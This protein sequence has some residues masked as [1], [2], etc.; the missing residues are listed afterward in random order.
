MQSNMTGAIDLKFKNERNGEEKRA[1]LTNVILVPKIGFNLLTVP[2]LNKRSNHLHM[3]NVKCSI[4][5][6]T[7]NEV[8]R[9]AQRKQD[10]LY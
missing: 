1:R 8:L 7:S 2:K 6:N 9:K 4:Y 3:R 5:N 10:G